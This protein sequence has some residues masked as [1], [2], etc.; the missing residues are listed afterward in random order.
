MLKLPRTIRLD[1]SDTFV[2]ERAAE[3]SEWAVSGAFAFWNSDVDALEGVDEWGDDD[4]AGLVGLAVLPEPLHDA[5]LALLDHVHHGA[6]GQQQRD[7]DDGGD[8]DASEAGAT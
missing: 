4:E 1:P 5:D 2:F 6:Q 7:D 3:P 8:D